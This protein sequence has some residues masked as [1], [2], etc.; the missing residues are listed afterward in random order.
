MESMQNVIIDDVLLEAGASKE[1]FN[2]WKRA[3]LFGL[4]ASFHI[5]NPYS[6]VTGA[7]QTDISLL[8]GRAA[9]DSNQDCKEITSMMT[10]FDGHKSDHFIGG[11]VLLDDD[12]DDEE[13][14]QE[15]GEGQDSEEDEEQEEEPDEKADRFKCMAKECSYRAGG[16]G[17]AAKTS[18]EKHVRKFHAERAEDLLKQIQQRYNR[19][20][21]HPKTDAD[22]K[23][24]DCNKE[25]RGN[26]AHQK[27]HAERC[28]DSKTKRRK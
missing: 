27:R 5:R 9:E 22:F 23:C 20:A 7:C 12:D 11:L 1:L 8:L 26:R 25:L 16:R 24:D 15:E 4:M 2:R 14:V 10:A 28:Q 21:L 3:Q 19:L 6:A 17:T 18:L 13:V